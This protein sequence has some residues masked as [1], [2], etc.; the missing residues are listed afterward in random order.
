MGIEKEVDE[1]VESDEEED[2]K[3]D[4]DDDDVFW[5]LEEECWKQKKG[6]CMLLIFFLNR[7]KV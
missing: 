3:D 4:D 2:N 6:L 5:S 1:D 7:F